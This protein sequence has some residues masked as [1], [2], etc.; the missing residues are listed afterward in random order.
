MTSLFTTLD[1]TLTWT[2]PFFDQIA[3]DLE[4]NGLA[5]FPSTK[6][7]GCGA[8]ISRTTDKGQRFLAYI[9]APDTD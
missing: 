4:A 9:S 7:D 5:E 6:M 8:L 3:G 2:R 1:E